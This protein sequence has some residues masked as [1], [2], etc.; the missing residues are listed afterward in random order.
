MSG[1]KFDNMFGCVDR[2]L[3]WMTKHT[4]AECRNDECGKK[5]EVFKT[6]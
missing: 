3:I 6:G 1:A 4:K 5:L 2:K